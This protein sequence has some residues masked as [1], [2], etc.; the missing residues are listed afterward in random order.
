MEKATLT[1]PYLET[2]STRDLVALAEEVG[3]DI[4]EG[5]NRRFIIGE[6]LE[7]SE[8]ARRAE[9]EGLQLADAEFS[10]SVEALPETYNETRV[11][12]LLRDPGWIFVYWD[13]HTTVFSSITGNHRFETFF[14]R[15]NSLDPAAVEQTRDF[16][17]VEVGTHDRKW[18]V[19]LSS[20][21]RACRVDLYARNAQEK[22]Q[23]LAR[24]SAIVVPVS[25]AF[26]APFPVDRRQPPLVELSGITALRKEHFR[27]HR[28]SF[29]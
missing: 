28:Q 3:I 22:E 21:E 10:A 2:L 26:E 19:H 14:L 24:S 5:L 13:F 16:F 23:L 4:P 12:V 20:G 25:R 11:T 7:I 17:D 9:A 6:L 1:K 18:Y 29:A 27:N 8:D 15:V